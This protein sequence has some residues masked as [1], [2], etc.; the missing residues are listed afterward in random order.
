MSATGVGHSVAA[1]QA[2]RVIWLFGLG[3]FAVYALYAGLTK[4]VTSARWESGAGLS[5]FELLPAV[6]LAT[7]VTLASILTAL[8]WWRFATYRLVAGLALPWPRPGL[9]VSG[10]GTAALIA[11]T[12]LAFSFRGVSVV[13]A[14]LMLRGGVLILAPLVDLAL[15]RSVRWFCWAAL[16]LSLGALALALSQ[17]GDYQLDAIALGTVACYLCGYALRLPMMTRLAKTADLEVAR[18]Y[19]VDEA[20]VAMLALPLIPPCL[21]LVGS[22]AIASASWRGLTT[23]WQGPALAPALAIGALYAGLFVFGTLIYLDRR[24]NTFCVPL[25]RGAS[26]FAGLVAS[27]AFGATAVPWAQLVGAG[28]MVGALLLLSPAHHAVEVALHI[29]NR[30]RAAAVAGEIERLSEKSSA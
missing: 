30:V 16:G 23:F 17:V 8:R 2:R 5:G 26:L 11:A 10:L 9:I 18:R 20:V 28:L 4:A 21:A 7:V 12:T 25:N 6:I 22:H 27:W 1:P 13:L 15:G 14:L 24:E 3:Y 19:F 29:R